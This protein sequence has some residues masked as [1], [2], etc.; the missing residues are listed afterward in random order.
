MIVLAGLLLAMPGMPEAAAGQECKICV[1][2]GEC[3][4]FLSSSGETCASDPEENPS[5]RDCSKEPDGHPG[6]HSTVCN[7]EWACSDHGGPSC[8]IVTEEDQ[9]EQELL[10]AMATGQVP[11]D[12]E[13][14][15]ALIARRTDVKYDP[16]RRVIQ[17]LG[18][19][20]SSLASVVL[21]VPVPP[22]EVLVLQLRMVPWQTLVFGT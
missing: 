5:C 7:A 11:F 14:V 16:V 15:G 1:Q 19:C 6:C 20:G 12:A 17:W 9:E 13:A 8:G 4:G 3:H 2:D 22:R 10:V 18:G 21:Q